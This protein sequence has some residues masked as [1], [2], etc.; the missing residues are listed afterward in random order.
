MGA[1]DIERSAGEWI[2]ILQQ[3]VAALRRYNPIAR[4]W[5][6]AQSNVQRGREETSSEISNPAGDPFRDPAP[7]TGM[8]FHTASRL[9]R[10]AFLPAR[11][12]AALSARYEPRLRAGLRARERPLS[13]AASGEAGAHRVHLG[14]RASLLRRYPL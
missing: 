11:C 1:L 7:I 9:R 3:R 13:A 10:A 12:L 2:S 4:D 6:P 14:V 8:G 5:G